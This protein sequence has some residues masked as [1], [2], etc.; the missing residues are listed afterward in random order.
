[1]GA[2]SN[3]ILSVCLGSSGN[4]N[5]ACTHA[6]E[7]S[8]QQMG[9][10]QNLNTLEDK[11]NKKV[12]QEA[13]EDIGESGI[14]VVGTG[15]FLVKSAVDKQITVQI[16]NAGVCDSMTSEIKADSYKLNLQW[17]F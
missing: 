17:K 4:T 3:A 15:A 10:E 8:Q 13:K 2:L 14:K 1:M 5:D 6:V 7:A 12:N 16:P 11:T 9:I